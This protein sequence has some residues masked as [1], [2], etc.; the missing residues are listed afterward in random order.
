M[1]FMRSI[2]SMRFMRSMRLVAA[3]L[4]ALCLLPACALAEDPASE[5]L[6]D[7]AALCDTLEAEHPNL[8]AT[9][10]EEV[11]QQERSALE[12]SAPAMS[13]AQFYY[14][15]RELVASVG[16][17]HTSLDFSDSWYAHLT[18]LPFAVL[19]MEHT[20][21]L[22]I[23]DEPNAAYLGW[24]VLAI[25]SVPMDE[26]FKRSKRLI[27]H[28]NDVWVAQNCSNT[29]NFLEALQYLDITPAEAS[30]VT[31][32]LRE[33][34]TGAE[35]ALTLQGLSEAEVSALKTVRLSPAET[36]MTQP[37]GYYSALL[38]DE[39][40]LLIQYNVCADWNVMPMSDFAAAVDGLFADT[41]YGKVVIDLRYNTGG[42]SS[43]W[44]PLL[45][46]LE[47]R[48][49]KQGFPVY[50]LIGAD[51]FSSGI[52]DALESKER[53]SATLVGSP[54]GGS[55]N[56][57][58]E[59]AF[60]DLPHIPISVC[61]STKYFELVPGYE[62]SSLLPDLSVETTLSDY[63]AGRDTVAEAVLAM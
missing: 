11:F 13:D 29:I 19:P 34:G 35:T 54:T 44:H 62:G 59:L 48:Q 28:E 37:N 41:A 20:W 21:Y 9:L 40:T 5:R 7:I 15:L 42:D 4:A 39:E 33:R 45:D 57:Y 58:G 43:V 61:Y 10:S 2:H 32:T 25:D 8:F 16:D 52:I 17:A 49:K 51:T 30:G 46:V 56:G 31:L 12:Q 50:T 18:A 26:V 53:L 60:F 14:A 23:V 1:R 63:L 38:P 3:L 47:R 27:S 22:A 6:A 55:V 36:P 24:E